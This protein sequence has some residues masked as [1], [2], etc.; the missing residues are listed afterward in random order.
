MHNQ[1]VTPTPQFDTVY[2]KRLAIIT[3]QDFNTLK[4][5]QPEGFEIK[6]VIAKESQDIDFIIDW[7]DTVLL[8]GVNPASIY[9]SQYQNIIYKKVFIFLDEKELFTHDAQRI[10]WRNITE[11]V[12][13]GEKI[14]VRAVNAQLAGQTPKQEMPEKLKIGFVTMWFERG[15]SYVTKTFRDV[16][17]RQ[18]E[19]F[20]FARQ[21]GVGV[22]KF[23][24]TEGFW[25]VPNLTTYDK[26]QIPPDVLKS[27]ISSNKLD[28]IIFNEEYDWNL[29]KTAK[30]IGVKVVTYLDFY[31]YDWTPFMR[32]FDAVIC[33]SKRTW[34]MVREFCSAYYVGWAINTDLFKPVYGNEKATFFHNAGWLGINYR[35]MT[36][37]AILAF[38]VVSKKHKDISLFI[39]AQ[40]GVEKLPFL[41]RDILKKN[42]KITWYN[43]TVSAPG[44]YHKGKY[45]LFP[46]KLEGLGLPLFEALSCG[47]PVICTNTAPMNEVVRDGV[48]GFEVQWASSRQRYDGV[49]F[50]ETIINVNSLVD[51]ME[52][53][54]QANYEA[55][56]KSAREYAVENFS[57][58]NFEKRLN[59]ILEGLYK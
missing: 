45:L 55:M 35:K 22:Q 58:D 30:D 28:V 7:A 23:L 3:P 8:V 40:V 4:E 36:P 48:T 44:L 13:V 27:W 38:D 14:N 51:A 53:A 41:V 15:Q 2:K 37:A 33:S 5:I 50:H 11:C 47:L 46:T 42:N 43:K 17:A 18:H 57:Q 56:S 9:A 16:L 1:T 39:H 26:Y 24:E 59:V 32:L 25:K 6:S 19:T 52:R 29:I 49:A 21:G 10:V 34:E 54:I 20:I 12:F 31:R